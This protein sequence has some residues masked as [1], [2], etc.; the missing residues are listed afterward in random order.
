MFFHGFGLWKLRFWIKNSVIIINKTQ[1]S[2]DIQCFS[3]ILKMEWMDLRFGTWRI[4]NSVVIVYKTQFPMDFQCFFH[5][6][7]L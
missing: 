4:E 1:F 6:F 2:K 7:R 3:W 5:G